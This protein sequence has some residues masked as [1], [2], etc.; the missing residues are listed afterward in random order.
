MHNTHVARFLICDG[1]ISSDQTSYAG[2]CCGFA[3]SSVIHPAT[4]IT[5]Y[6]THIPTLKQVALL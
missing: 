1:V 5:V 2:S 4:L 3:V 6:Q